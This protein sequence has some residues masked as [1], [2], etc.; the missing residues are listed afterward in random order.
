MTALACPLASC[1]NISTRFGQPP[2]LGGQTHTG[3]DFPAP[4]MTPVR[5]PAAG[6]VRD[7]W[8]NAGG[9]RMVAIT[10]TDSLETRYAHLASATVRKGQL[11]GAGEVIAYSGATGALV[12]G[13]H[14]HF[15][16][17]ENGRAV[18]PLP[19]LS[20]RSGAGAAKS[21]PVCAGGMDPNTM[22]S[23]VIPMPGSGV[24]PAG[25]L[26]TTE[27]ALGGIFGADVRDA[28]RDPLS[29][30]LRLPEFVPIAANVGL[31]LAAVLVG[32]GG[33]RR[34]LDG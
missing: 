12:R 2:A 8:W 11:V 16:A 24:C 19:Y 5:A 3:V 10:H 22:L 15:E 29:T 21:T 20:G 27:E 18:D 25:Y 33:V 6:V 17:W 34:I 14:L 26:A 23:K 9:G 13:A 7:V 31:L 28:L 30:V 4:T 1:A 32:W